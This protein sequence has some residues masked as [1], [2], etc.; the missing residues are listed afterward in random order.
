MT[1]VNWYI[2]ANMLLVLACVLMFLLKAVRAHS[3]APVAYSHQL[4]F[5]HCLAISAVLLPCL[6]RLFGSADFATAQVW[7]AATMQADAAY[8]PVDHRISV[9]LAAPHASVP[10]TVVS[11]FATALFLAGLLILLIRVAL[12]AYVTS[13]IIVNGHTIRRRGRL[14][15]LASDHTQIPFSFWLPARYFIVVP[16]SLTLRMDELKIVLR[17]EAQHHRQFDTKLLY[18]YQLLKAAFFWNPAVHVLSRRIVELQEFACDETLT[19]RRANSSHAY[20]QLLLRLAETA[21]RPRHA[22]VRMNM[23]GD[24]AG[25]LERRVAAILMRPAHYVRKPAVAVAGGISFALM[26]AAAFVFASPIHDRRISL[27]QTLQMAAIARQDSAFPIVVNDEVVEQL[28]RLLGTPDG[29]AYLRAS[30]DRMRRY[31]AAVAQQIT[32]YG[33]PPEL[34]A[35]PLVESGYLNAPHDGNPRNGAGLWRFIKPTA[36]RYGLKVDERNDQR[37]DAHAETDAAM[38]YFASLHQRFNDWGLALLAFNAGERRV[39][40]GIRETGS[41]DVWEIISHGYE[42]D[43]DYVPRVTAAIIIIKNRARV[44]RSRHRAEI[45]L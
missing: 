8:S 44:L 22:L 40:H 1:H 11:R 34:L 39:E 28:N 2:C 24:E 19:G 5:A 9:A 45:E 29:D 7:S 10:L 16:S 21:V 32:Q 4:Y 33:M 20:C 37:L 23:I 31:E 26:A 18:L 43:P 25:T 38:R 15:I 13:R 6:V 3:P 14:R 17:H 35:V 30:V 41:R 12:D 36:Q 42:N 27:E